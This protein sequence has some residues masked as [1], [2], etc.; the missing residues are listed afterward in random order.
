MLPGWVTSRR[1]QVCR[2]IFLNARLLGEHEASY[3]HRKALVEAGLAPPED[4]ANHLLW[5]RRQLREMEANA[6]LTPPPSGGGMSVWGSEGKGSRASYNGT[7][8]SQRPRKPKPPEI[9]APLGVEMTW[10]QPGDAASVASSASSS[11]TA[12]ADWRRQQLARGS[13]WA[14]L[15]QAGSVSEDG[16]PNAHPARNWLAAHQASTGDGRSEAVVS[17]HRPPTADSLLH[18]TGGLEQG[19]GGLGSEWE[20]VGVDDDDDLQR[21]QQL[22]QYWLTIIKTALAQHVEPGAA[23]PFALRPRS[24]VPITLEA[25]GLDMSRGIRFREGDMEDA[26]VGHNIHN[27]L[28]AQELQQGVTE[29]SLEQ[30]VMFDLAELPSD[31]VIKVG[32]R[33]YKPDVGT[34]AAPPTST[35]PFRGEAE[36]EQEGEEEEEGCGGGGEE[37]ALRRLKRRTERKLLVQLGRMWDEKADEVVSDMRDVGWCPHPS[38]NTLP[39]PLNLRPSTPTPNTSRYTKPEGA[40]GL[41]QALEEEP[42]LL[43][44][45]VWVAVSLRAYAC[46]RA[47]RIESKCARASVLGRV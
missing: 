16:P 13:D 33:F 5:V 37:D 23:A 45:Q 31:A 32:D 17:P 1:A 11:R 28:L 41:L 14:A 12:R 39:S 22:G 30:L 38:P 34:P 47:C 25:A 46:M 7:L 26:I 15:L 10:E 2:R 18:E 35:L 6:P 3:G 8:P 42:R 29:F 44:R 36:E 43:W 24:G 40:G 27:T 9:R 19:D 20:Q 21:V 4:P